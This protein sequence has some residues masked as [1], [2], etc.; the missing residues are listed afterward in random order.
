MDDPRRPGMIFAVSLRL[1]HLI[2]QHMLGL[3][4]LMART[5]S[6]K[7]IELLVLARGW[8][9]AALCAGSAPTWHRHRRRAGPSPRPSCDPQSAAPA[10]LERLRG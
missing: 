7:D 5:S 9:F 6:T 8:S 2:F 1:L 3:L 4:L 10:A